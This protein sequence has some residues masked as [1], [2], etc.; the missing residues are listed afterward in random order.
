MKPTSILLSIGTALLLLAAE[1][2]TQCTTNYPGNNPCYDCCTAQLPAGDGDPVYVWTPI[3]L[4][5]EYLLT[6]QA[7]SGISRVGS[8]LQF[9]CW[10]RLELMMPCVCFITLLLYIG[11]SIA[12]RDIAS[13]INFGDTVDNEYAPCSWGWNLLD[14]Y[15]AGDIKRLI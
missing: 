15:P 9:L 6:L 11:S 4:N 14:V 1:A 2:A 3:S 7:W 10:I 8:V 12:N 13:S 5:W